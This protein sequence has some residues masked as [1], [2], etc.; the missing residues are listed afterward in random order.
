MS[1]KGIQSASAHL[2]SPQLVRQKSCTTTVWVQEQLTETMRSL[3]LV[4]GR[5]KIWVQVPQV[6]QV[7]G[8]CNTLPQL[9]PSS[10]KLFS[11]IVPGG[12]HTPAVLTKPELL[13]SLLSLVTRS[14]NLFF[15]LE[16]NPF[17]SDDALAVHQ[18]A[19]FLHI[20]TSGSEWF[21][22]LFQE[23]PKP[24][25]LGFYCCHTSTI[26]LHALSYNFWVK[27][28]KRTRESLYS[29][30]CQR[31][32]FL[33]QLRSE[34]ELFCLLWDDFHLEP[35]CMLVLRI[36]TKI[37]KLVQKALNSQAQA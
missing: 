4:R 8:I 18:S 5:I 33:A 32:S 27:N 36:K 37:F 17:F 20:S 10:P 24:C 7:P 25:L 22:L 13:S 23:T 29:P 6:S 12:L 9:T 3:N 15:R 31:M 1:H 2:C 28:Y 30:V 19:L 35:F 21:P 16:S 14:T 11:L 34:N 26:A